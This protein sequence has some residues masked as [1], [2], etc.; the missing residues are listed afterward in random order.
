MTLGLGL[1]LPVTKVVRVEPAGD[2]GDVRVRVDPRETHSLTLNNFETAGQCMLTAL[3]HMNETMGREKQEQG[4]D[5]SSSCCCS[6]PGSKDDAVHRITRQKLNLINVHTAMCQSVIRHL[7]KRSLTRANFCCVILCTAC[8]TKLIVSAW[9]KTGCKRIACCWGKQLFF[10]F[11]LLLFSFLFL[12]L[13]EK[14]FVGCACFLKM[15]L[16]LRCFPF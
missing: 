14:N 12:N 9:S 10:S 1:S 2:R 4:M 15:V 7:H 11:T 5:F 16:P 3:A 8:G 6:F 13:E